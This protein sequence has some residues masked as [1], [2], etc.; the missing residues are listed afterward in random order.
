MEDFLKFKDSNVK[1]VEYIGLYLFVWMP[2]KHPTNGQMK[3]LENILKQQ[4]SKY[5]ATFFQSYSRGEKAIHLPQIIKKQL[6]AI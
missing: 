1:L 3:K 4:H 2:Y 6:V 5:Y